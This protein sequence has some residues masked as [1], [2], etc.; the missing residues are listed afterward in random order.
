MKY[1]ALGEIWKTCYNRCALVYI[2]KNFLIRNDYFH[3]ENNIAVSMQWDFVGM[4]PR[5]NVDVFWCIF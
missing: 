5:E 1:L 2:L 3:I 4:L